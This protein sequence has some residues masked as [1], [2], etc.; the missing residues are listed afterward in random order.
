MEISIEK[1]TNVTPP[2]LPEEPI[3]D[4]TFVA[5]SHSDWSDKPLIGRVMKSNG[6]SVTIHW[7]IGRY[8]GK[9]K[10]CF[11]KING[12]SEPHLEDIPTRTVVH[13]FRW[14]VKECLPKETVTSLREAYKSN[15][16]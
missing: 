3:T 4:D 13:R 11:I 8:S 14:N 15:V 16:Q 1:P 7:C 6:N 12:V 10:E 9:W 5:F 2:T